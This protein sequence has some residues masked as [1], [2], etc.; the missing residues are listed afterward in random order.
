MLSPAG[1]ASCAA[2]AVSRCCFFFFPLSLPG[3]MWLSPSPPATIRQRLLTCTPSCPGGCL[4]DG[5]ARSS[6]TTA[7]PEAS[8][9]VTI[10]R[11]SWPHLSFL[12]A[13]SDCPAASRLSWYPAH[14]ARLPH[15]QQ[16]N[17]LLQRRRSLGPRRHPPPGRAARDEWSKTRAENTIR[18]PEHRLGSAPCKRGTLLPRP[19]V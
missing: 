9:P 8:C 5:A 10:L 18:I 2:P 14:V 4:F 1:Q 15:H 16:A 7:R 11:V 13:F 19:R 3:A 6:S 17:K 12:N